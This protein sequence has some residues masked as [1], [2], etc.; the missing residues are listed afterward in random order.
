M[1]ERVLLSIDTTSSPFGVNTGVS[2]LLTDSD[3]M[4]SFVSLLSD[5]AFCL[6]SAFDVEVLGRFDI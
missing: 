6:E 5:D 1:S 4:F 3:K 2:F